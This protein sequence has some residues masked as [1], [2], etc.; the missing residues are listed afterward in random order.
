MSVIDEIIRDAMHK[1]HFDALPGSGK[2]LKLEDDSMV[3]AAQ[4]MAYKLLRDNQLVPDWMAQ[5]QELDRAREKLTL[6]VRR[7]DREYHGAL[8]DAQRSTNPALTR[9]QVEDRWLVTVSG[10]REQGAQHNRQ[11]LSYN[12]KVPKGVTHKRQLDIELELN[13]VR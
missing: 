6:A 9:K 13:K 5:G 12:L 7:A 10:L 8:N 11:V 1:G 2:P 4:R 3:P